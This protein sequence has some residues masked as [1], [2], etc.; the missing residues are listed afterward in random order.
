MNCK[1]DERSR[2]SPFAPQAKLHPNGFRLTVTLLPQPIAVPPPVPPVALPELPPV[3]P[4]PPVALPLV[5][6]VVV[7]PV[8]AV[9]PMLGVPAVPPADEPLE[10]DAPAEPPVAA[11]P[12]PPSPPSEFSPPHAFS[13]ITDERKRK[14]Q[15]RDE[16]M[17]SGLLVREEHQECTR[18]R[19]YGKRSG[20]LDGKS[21][22]R[23]RFLFRPRRPRGLQLPLA[24]YQGPTGAF[25]S[26]EACQP[27]W[28]FRRFV[29]PARSRHRVR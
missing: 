12:L 19:R 10:P 24:G 29:L 14:E 3:G 26:D 16:I 22:Q 9:P 17:P 11:P 4:V 23:Y 25:S 27:A 7:P 18:S 21:S 1:Y 15:I 28:N 13:A 8:G 6:P 20:A 5:P 2:T